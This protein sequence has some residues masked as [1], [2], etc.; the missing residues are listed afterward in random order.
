MIIGSSGDV[1]V[2]PGPPLTSEKNLKVLTQNCRGLGEHA[3]LKLILNKSY[4]FIKSNP[5]NLVLL[6]ETMITS[7]SQIAIAW[8]GNY[9]FTPGTGHGRGCITL[10]SSEQT[11]ISSRQIQDRG[12]LISLQRKTN[13]LIVANIYAPTT[14]N[15]EKVNFFNQ[16]KD[17]INEIREPEDDVILAGNLNTIFEDFECKN[18]SF[19]A[20]EKTQSNRIKQILKEI[21]PNDCWQ[22]NKT[23]HTW[24]KN[25]QSSRLDRI[26][27]EVAGWKLKQ[28]EADWTFT[29]SDHAAV[30]AT[31]E[32]SGPKMNKSCH[33]PK[34]DPY[35]LEN[36][37]FKE[38]FIIEYRRLIREELDEWEP[39][40][41]L[42]FHKCAIRSAYA[43]TSESFNKRQ[44]Q[45]ISKL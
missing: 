4:N 45:T 23:T 2:N 5:S 39:H 38:A 17:A 18:R 35:K 24:R 8:R 1:E 36:R 3:K 29:N 32:Q 33:T 42:E 13:K 12:H 44:K 21:T 9:I 30:I 37:E 26:M 7:P 27:Y 43:N 15:E 34:L 11:P 31:F 6:Q 10:L 20:R 25:R 41:A 16:V 40:L 28:C 22:N 19:T 14:L